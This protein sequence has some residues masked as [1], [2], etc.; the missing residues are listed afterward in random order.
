MG[1][2]SSHAPKA[3]SGPRNEP[4]RNPRAFVEAFRGSRVSSDVETKLL[5]LGE[6]SSPTELQKARGVFFFIPLFAADFT[7]V[8]SVVS[9][10][11]P[12]DDPEDRAVLNSAKELF[13]RI[14]AKYPALQTHLIG[15]M[16]HTGC[17]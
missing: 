10:V 9:I 2:S 16:R 15:A 14:E 8:E 7:T 1:N 6:L 3:S 17:V 11:C 4:S 13:Q 5:K 12:R